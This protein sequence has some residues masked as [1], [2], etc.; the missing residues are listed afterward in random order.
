MHK[1]D[2]L[3]AALVAACPQFVSDPDRLV[4][5]VDKG[6]LV[7]RMTAADLAGGLRYEWRYI[8]RLEFHDYI[9]SPDQIAVALLLWLR[10]Y[11]PDRLLDFVREDSA[12]G[13]AADIIDAE[14]CD[15]VFSFELTEA[16][17]ATRGIDGRW[18]TANL[19][20]P[21]IAGTDPLLGLDGEIPL[22]GV[23]VRVAPRP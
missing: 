16:V 2:H 6:R 1:I 4:I 21:P 15:L 22:A 23:E 3:R 12:L 20:E 19:T 5:F 13:F 18:I 17:E 9:G 14:T 7:S 11:Q 8:V 10:Q